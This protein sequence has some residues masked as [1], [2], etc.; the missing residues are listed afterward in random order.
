MAAAVSAFLAA[1]RL[2]RGRHAGRLRVARVA[3]L[4]LV[5]RL[6]ASDGPVLLPGGRAR[7]RRVRLVTTSGDWSNLGDVLVAGS[8][9]AGVV[10]RRSATSGGVGV[11][12]RVIDGG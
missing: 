10:W 12:D 9:T 6:A 1:I 7:L 2:E 11:T 3:G 8:V 5:G 4:R